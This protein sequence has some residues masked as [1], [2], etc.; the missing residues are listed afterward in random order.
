[1]TK[2]D[3]MF[4]ALSKIF[5]D[6]VSKVVSD[7]VDDLKSAIKD[8]DLNRISYNQNFQTRL[9]QL[10]IDTLNRFTYNKYEK[11]DKL[12]DA[13]ESILKGFISTKDNIDAVK[14]GLKIL[15]SDVNNDTCKDFLEILYEEI[16]KDDNS[17]LYK[18]I[19][20]L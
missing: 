19:D 9:Y 2:M 8:A 4:M 16:C 10:I 12:Y 1:M 15:I 13:S 11:Q 3:L 7:C 5:G 17:D 18:E 20:M 6:F 14:L